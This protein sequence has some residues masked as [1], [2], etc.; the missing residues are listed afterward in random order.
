MI[1]SCLD[2][3]SNGYLDFKEFHQALLLLSAKTTD[4]K[5]EYVPIFVMLLYEQII[6]VGLS[7]LR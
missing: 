6:K 1:F 4:Q 2:G 5:L 7:N 3:D